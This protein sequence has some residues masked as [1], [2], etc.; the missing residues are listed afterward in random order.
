[1]YV[2]YVYIYMYM[3]TMYSLKTILTVTFKL[4]LSFSKIV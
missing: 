2:K 3:H 1:M 4:A